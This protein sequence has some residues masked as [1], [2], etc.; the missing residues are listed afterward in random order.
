[1]ADVAKVVER[2]GGDSSEI[3]LFDSDRPELLPYATLMTARSTGPGDF[4]AV[5]GAYEWQGRPLMLLVAGDKL[6]D[7]LHVRRLRRAAAMRGDAPY[8]GVVNAGTL[9]VFHVALDDHD[10]SASSIALPTADNEIVTA[11]P[12]LANSRP[13]AARRNWISDVVLRLLTA[14]IDALVN[15]GVGDGDAISLVGRA[16]FVR[17]LAD[18]FM[19]TTDT[20]PLGYKDPSVLFDSRQAIAATSLWLDETFNGDFLPLSETVVASLS[21]EAV[22]RLGDVLRRAP[23]GQLHLEWREAWDRLD[24]A[25]IPVGVLSQAYERYLSKHDP[26]V[27]QREG[28]Y[29]TPRHIADL[30]VKA[31]FTALGRE[32]HAVSARILDPAAGAGVFL[33]TAFRQLVAERWRKDG[34]RPDTRVLRSILYEQVVGFDI[35]ESALRFA[36]LGLY[37]MSIELDPHPEP[38][39]KLRFDNLRPKVLNKFSAARRTPVAEDS[40]NEAPALGSLGVEVSD[41]HLGAYDLVIGNPPWA[42]ST[43]LRGWKWLQD[44]VDQIV[45]K[46][47]SDASASAPLPNEVLDLPFVWRA[48]EWAKPRGQIAFA[49]HARLLFQQGETMPEA[50]GALFSAL[51]VT[52]V[53]NGTE[54]RTTKVWPEISAP[55]MLLFAR[56]QIPAPGAGFRFVTP[57]LE[58][59]LNSAG[60]WRVDVS[61]ADT[62]ASEEVRARPALLKALFRGSRLDLEILDRI[63]SLSLPSLDQYWRQLFGESRG[64][65]KDTGNGYQRLRASSEIQQHGDGRP[66]VAAEYLH[67]IPLLNAAEFYS[68]DADVERLSV[69]NEARIHRRRPIEIFRGPLLIVKESPPV[70]HGRI[71]VSVSRNDVVYNQSYHGYS[72]GRHEAGSLLTRYLALVIGSNLTL[73]RALL[74]SGRFGFEREVIEKFI[75][76]NTPIV[77]LESLSVAEQERINALFERTAALDNEEVWAEVDAWVASLYGLT[78]NDVQVVVDT[79]RYNLP[80]SENKLLAQRSSTADMRQTFCDVLT[81]ELS[82]W[83]A[84]FGRPLVGTVVEVPNWSPWRFIYLGE[85]RAGPIESPYQ[86]GITEAADAMAATE[87]IVIGNDSAHLWIGRLDQ[88]RYWSGSQAKLIARKLIWEQLNFLSGGK[89]A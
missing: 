88:A 51:D 71:R 76:D 4:A 42:V 68:L 59:R 63:S 47:L 1:M 61:N 62:V 52:G 75:I 17:F 60:A 32:G 18:R 72:A 26:E 35:N 39:Q 89:A 40:V 58:D 13:Y 16:L 73:W 82:A 69:F 48:T 11:I 67:G 85:P 64:K 23:G 22:V 37:L 9:T 24:F 15:E 57:H 28:G 6:Q 54:L 74:T 84:K 50:R 46:R 10:L 19:L 55:F 53:I 43:Q 25:H 80:F 20:L 33:L 31:A 27:Q 49:L 21:E 44:R 56:N 29:Y 3:L 12:F 81:D 70:S 78:I 34:A 45:R 30:M 79:L 86:A 77:P 5:C 8:L 2:Y 7:E 66:G 65:P 14:S 83:A 38:L 41:E 36:A 87:I